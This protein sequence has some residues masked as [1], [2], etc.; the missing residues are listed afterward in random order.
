MSPIFG[1]RGREE[2]EAAIRSADDVLATLDG[3]GADLSSALRLRDRARESLHDRDAKAALEQARRAEATAKLLD[4]LYGAA[5]SGIKRLRF[6]RGRMSKFGMDLHEVDA[7]VQEASAWMGRSVER[8]GDPDFPA[9]A[10]AA[11]VALRGLKLAQFRIPRY[12]AAAAVVADA[13][14]AVRETVEANR[15]V[16]EEAFRFFVLKPATDALEGAYAKLRANEFPEATELATSTRDKARAILETYTRVTNAYE[17]AAE[18]ARALKAEGAAVTEAEDLLA[19]SRSALERGKFEDAATVAGQAAEK[20]GEIR[21][22]YRGLVLRRR[23]AEETIKEVEQWGFD[24]REPRAILKSARSKME[25]ARYGEAASLFDEARAAAHNLRDAHRSTAARILEMR[26]SVAAVRPSNPR[27]ATEAAGLLTKAE[28]L[29]D[30]G[31]YRQAEEDL[32]LAALLLAGP[33]GPA[34]PAVRRGLSDLA[35]A[36]QAAE[37]RCPTC[38]GPV[39][40]DGTCPTCSAS[41]ES[42][43]TTA[44]EVDLIQQA[45]DQAREVVEEIA[46][47]QEPSAAERA[48]AQVQ[49]C[50]MCG[51]PLEGE[52]TL[53]ARCQALVKGRAA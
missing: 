50:A 52:D 3:G 34:A 39:A 40:N 42:E 44:T 13:E 15:F 31:R 53:C 19:V 20:L 48:E 46:R 1:G 5:T 51:G 30:E 17:G 14:D 32:Q 18:T 36:V 27:A 12:K 9:Y 38:G 37:P 11:E 25:A 43:N 35:D 21:Q 26:R 8:D 47:E 41:P 33:G 6:E 29:L 16:A 22:M 45:V 10:K 49:G 28:G 24:A 2:A 7:L 23:N 4:R